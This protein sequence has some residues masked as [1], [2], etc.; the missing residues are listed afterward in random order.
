MSKYIIGSMLML[1]LLLGM[2]VPAQALTS[3]EAEAIISALNLNASQ[4]AAIRALVP[5]STA[6]PTFNYTRNLTIGSTG[7]DVSAIQQYLVSKGFLTMPAGVAYGYFGNLTRSALAAYQA[8]V[9]LPGTGY[10]GPMT[11][12]H[13][14]AL[15]PVAGN[16]GNNGNQNGGNQNGN[17]G[18]VLQGDEGDFRNFEILGSP[19]NEDVNEGERKQVFGFEFEAEDSDIRVD[20]LDLIFTPVGN[21]NRP[22]EFIRTITLYKGN[23][24]IGT[25][26]VGNRNDWSEDNDVYR[27]RLNNL[28]RTNSIVREGDTAQFFV[29]I[30]AQNNLDSGDL[31]QRYEIAI[32]D[33]GLRAI[34]AEGINLYEGDESDTVTVNFEEADSGELEITLGGSEN[35]DRTERVN[36]NS[37]SSNIELLNFTVESENSD[38][39]IEDVT[40]RVATSSG[41]S[42]TINN[43][44]RTVRLV[45]DG[46]VIKTKSIPA[47]SNASVNITFDNL[48]Y[49]I[50]QGDEVTFEVQADI[51]EQD[52]NFA[53]GAGLQVTLLSIEAEDEQGDD[54]TETVNE[55]GGVVAFYTSG[56][57]AR[58][59]SS[60]ATKSFVADDAGEKDRNEYVI[61]FDLTAYGED[62]YIDN[63]VVNA[64]ASNLTAGNG[65][66]WAT[67]TNTTGSYTVSSQILSAL[68]H[69]NDDTADAYIIDRGQTR[70]FSLRVMITAESDGAAGIVLTGI[71]WDTDG[72]SDS[73]ADQFYTTNLG[74]FRTDTISLNVQ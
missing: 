2:A 67:T 14:R 25:K 17:N 46:D 45:V 8:S 69:D 32:A 19:S 18:D 12:A 58:F 71:N 1:S 43:I 41:T 23:T 21:D 70:S 16:N 51:N 65:V 13:L 64:V 73:T 24:Q 31:P 56:I 49:E 59:V 57:S 38:S 40:I 66:S 74:S 60:S 4:A 68:D 27:V 26:N 30:T 72:E 15:P 20:R 10:F 42:N 22:S 61:R 29:E 50:E 35:R 54:I 6:A 28:H 36:E 55:T 47:N 3:V 9:G 7:A 63:S 52:G 48:D 39:V 34:D 5:N 62:I 11:I 53:N 33:E 44:A 37:R